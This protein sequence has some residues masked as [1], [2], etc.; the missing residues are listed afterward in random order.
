ME[1]QQTTSGLQ[2]TIGK[3]S[4]GL[5]K[6]LQPLTTAPDLACLDERGSAVDVVNSFFKE[7]EMSPG[8]DSTSNGRSKQA[9]LEVGKP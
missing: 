5:V 2:E 6:L 9:I 1:M 8:S 3:E 7:A 4:A